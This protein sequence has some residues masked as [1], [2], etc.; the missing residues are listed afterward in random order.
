MPRYYFHIDGEKPHSDGT[1]EEL[2]HDAR[3]WE[4]A[5][6]TVRDIESG[7]PQAINGRWRSTVTKRQSSLLASRRVV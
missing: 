3:A 4:A 6:R 5:V 2:E 1:G 7:S